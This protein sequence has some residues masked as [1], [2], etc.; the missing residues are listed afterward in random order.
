MAATAAILVANR[1]LPGELADKGAWE[2]AVFW[3][4][5][6]LAFL[7]AAWRSAAVR[8]ARIS[9][10]WREQCLVI[11]F[12]GI[13][14]VILNAVTTG[15]HLINTLAS[16]YWPVAGVD[17]AL[18]TVSGLAIAAAVKLNR[19]EAAAMRQPSDTATL[20]DAGADRA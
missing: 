12:L 18:V 6:L 11:A 3:M 4:V 2:E 20:V 13:S 16:G 7:H 8:D 17:L 19:R 9:P 5:W 10:A 14:A 15:D 1:L